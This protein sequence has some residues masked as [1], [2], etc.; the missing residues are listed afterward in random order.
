MLN[1]K[2]WAS[3]TN[4]LR[5]ILACLDDLNLGNV[6]I[7]GPQPQMHS[8]GDTPRVNS[9]AVASLAQK[10]GEA[11]KIRPYRAQSSASTPKLRT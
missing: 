4:E 10:N 11:I 1:P 3:T 5:I 7:T 2:S 8:I 6:L 9:V